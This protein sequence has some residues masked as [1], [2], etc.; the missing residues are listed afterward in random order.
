MVGE[1]RE[2]QQ[3]QTVEK[4]YS[5]PGERLI[6]HILIVTGCIIVAIAG[7]LLRIFAVPIVV[8][9]YDV[10]LKSTVNAFSNLGL[11]I[12]IFLWAL[13]VF[14]LIWTLGGFPVKEIVFSKE[15]LVFRRGRKPII[16]QRVTDLKEARG[17]RIVKL[18]GLTPEGNTVT[19]RLNWSDVGR[20]K[21]EEFKKDLQKIKASD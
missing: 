19:R 4:V 5:N 21:W 7:L 13:L 6:V 3:S 11:G 2:S 15:G 16:I 20:K 1:E 12:A 10:A 8:A 14:Y 18:T 9:L 17:G